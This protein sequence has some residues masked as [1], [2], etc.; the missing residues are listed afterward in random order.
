M[1]LDISFYE[2]VERVGPH[3]TEWIDDEGRQH[4][5]WDDLDH[6]AVMLWSRH[7]QPDTFVFTQRGLDSEFHFIPQGRERSWSMSYGGYSLFR[8]YL[9]SLVRPDLVLAERDRESSSYYP[10]AYDLS[11]DE[12]YSLPFAELLDFADNEGTYSGEVAAELARDF[13]ANEPLLDATPGPFPAWTNRFREAYRKYAACLE[14]V[15][16]AG[17]VDYH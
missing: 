12:F 16:P 7:E 11:D 15:G 5:C 10:R 14:V 9:L 3:A 4:E 17:L 13:R 8:A 6:R 2:S 1:G